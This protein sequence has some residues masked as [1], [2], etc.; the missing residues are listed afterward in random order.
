MDFNQT[1]S[2]IT[3][4]ISGF[5]L[6]LSNRNYKNFLKESAEFKRQYEEFQKQDALIQKEIEEI[7]A[8]LVI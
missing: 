8:F 2:F 6:Y 7:K 3:L 5:S 4:V 1:L